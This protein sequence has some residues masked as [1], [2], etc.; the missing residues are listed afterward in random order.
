MTLWV[1]GLNHQT[2][3]L[4]VRERVVFGAEQLTQAKYRAGAVTRL[5][6]SLKDIFERPDQWYL[7]TAV[8]VVSLFTYL[9]WE[10]AAFLAPMLIMLILLGVTANVAGSIPNFML[11]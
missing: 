5:G 6:Q 1:L 3:P 8:D 9:S 11:T 4:D 2:A 10:I 7:G